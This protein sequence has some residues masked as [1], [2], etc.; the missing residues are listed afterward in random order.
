MTP[1]LSLT[2]NT[3]GAMLA[4]YCRKGNQIQSR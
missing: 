3:I 1:I 2:A 4:G